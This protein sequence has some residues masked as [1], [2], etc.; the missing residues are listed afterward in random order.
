M[1]FRSL[2]LSIK[3]IFQYIFPGKRDEITAWERETL[4]AK[5][6]EGFRLATPELDPLLISTT[7]ALAKAA[8]L[9]ECPKVIIYRKDFPNAHSLWNSTIAVSTGAIEKYTPDELETVLAHELTH[10]LHKKTDL[11]VYL[12]YALSTIIGAVFITKASLKAF[13]TG[14]KG[15]SFWDILLPVAIFTAAAEGIGVVLKI[16]VQAYVRMMEKN[17]DRGAFLLTGK[18]EAM[19]SIQRVI[20]KREN[21]NNNRE[22]SPIPPTDP[23]QQVGALPPEKMQ[24]VEPASPIRDLMTELYRSHPYPRERIAYIEKLQKQTETKGGKKVI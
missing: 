11:L 17:A 9:K 7:T 1:M 15:T 19:K 18:G 22:I 2:Y 3:H 13:G 6:S 8:G 12:S 14:R 23:L 4:M 5:T 24:T 16:P 20:E 10:N 21:D